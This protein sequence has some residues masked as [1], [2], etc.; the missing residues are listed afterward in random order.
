MQ[1]QTNVQGEAAPKRKG[2]RMRKREWREKWFAMTE[3]ATLEAR[4]IKQTMRG[5]KLLA[6]A[7]P[8]VMPDVEKLREAGVTVGPPSSWTKFAPPAER[9]ELTDFVGSCCAAGMTADEAEALFFRMKRNPD[10]IAVREFEKFDQD[11]S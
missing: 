3:G 11:I 4:A 8:R 2:R 7:M 6:N 5:P 1:L 10:L 9:V